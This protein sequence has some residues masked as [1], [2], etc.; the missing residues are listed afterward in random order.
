MSRLLG[1][2]T[3]RLL[4]IALAAA[5]MTAACASDGDAPTGAQTGRTTATLESLDPEPI[6][7]HPVSALPVSV[8]SA[9]G[10]D[11]TITDT[12]RIGGA[13]P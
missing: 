11:V 3:S 1:A 6:A 5:A 9:D 13:R 4:A 7:E 2:R 12:S 8:R 10:V